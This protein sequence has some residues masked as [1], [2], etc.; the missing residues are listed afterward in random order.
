MSGEAKDVRPFSNGTEAG[1]WRERNCERC[2]LNKWDRFTN[3]DTGTCEME[4]AVAHGFITGKI[5]AT[6]ATEYGATVRG[7][8]CDLP[9]ECPKLDLI[10]RCEYVRWPGTRRASKCDRA[11]SSEVVAHGARRAVCPRHAKLAAAD[12]GVSS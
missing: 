10:Q 1:I 2:V 7:A 4:R 9:R 8:Y 3:D 11:A 12:P 5:P 6:L